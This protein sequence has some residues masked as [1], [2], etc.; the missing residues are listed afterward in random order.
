MSAEATPAPKSIRGTLGTFG[1][2]FT[3]SLLTILGV[4][5]FLR[6]GYVTGNAGLDRTLLIVLI[7]NAV[8]I[9]TSLSLAVIATN[10]PVAG[11]GDYF[12]ISRS[13]GLEFGGAIGAVLYVA[14][15]VSVGFYVVGFTE[16][17]GQMV[18]GLVI[19]A[20]VLGWTVPEFLV[21]LP[22][23]TVASL[24]STWACLC[25]FYLAYRGADI[26][27]KFQ[28][29]IMAALGLALLSYFVGAGADFDA[30]KIAANRGAGY[31]EGMSFWAVFAIFFPAITGFTQGVSMS[32]DLKDPKKSLPLGTFAAVGVS[33][34]VYLA[35]PFVL[36][37][38]ADRA[39][40]L[41]DAGAETMKRHALVPWLVDIGVFAATLSSALA[42]LMGAPRILRAMS[43]D[44]LFPGSKFFAEGTAG[45]SEPRRA[46]LLT[47]SI[48]LACIWLGD[49]NALAAVVTMFFLLSYGAVNY[50]TFLEGFSRNPSFRPRF[51]FSGWRT[52]LAG[53]LVC[54][55]VMLAI[56][57]FATVIAL[58]VLWGIHQ[59]LVWRD[60]ESPA[61][62]ARRGFYLQRIK[63]YLLLLG[64]RPHHPRSWRPVVLAAMRRGDDGRPLG[65]F[66]G[67]IGSAQ[68]ILTMAVV[69]VGKFEEMVEPRRR[70]LEELDRFVRTGEQ[71]FFFE[72]PIAESFPAGIRSLLLTHGIGQLRPN[73]LLL[74]WQSE[75]EG[76][77][78][79]VLGDAAALDYHVVLFHPARTEGPFATDAAAVVGPTDRIIDVWWRGNA[80][81]ALALLLAHLVSET[82][83]WRGCRIRVLRIVAT[84]AER[85]PAGADL[86]AL[87]ESAR[88]VATAEVVVADRPAFD[89][90]SQH[91]GASHLVFLGV[92]SVREAHRPDLARYNDVL[93]R[94]PTT[95]LVSAAGSFDVS[96]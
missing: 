17:L 21:R 38:T 4:I 31:A 56:D 73:T 88:F 23:G 14:Q 58:A 12:L 42:S 3:P 72:V 60:L 65:R 85:E 33:L 41:T 8:S 55:A 1:G 10:T 35:L 22:P 89:V 64:D 30:S 78:L 87:I 59:Y 62:D 45:A 9:L 32:G 83:D 94:L 44:E 84:D 25:L 24:V 96:V 50:A 68:G 67:A 27:T 52:S 74:R 36:A 82:R 11:G 86:T 70:Q 37:G 7:A 53:A 13:V 51:R 28:Y 34:V 63:D 46:M 71:R 29:V 43:L 92:G 19:P 15:S 57:P 76:E 40:L 47:L 77:Y 95:V 81:G 48:A 26:A 49:L 6:F 2:V 16:A 20:H 54:A 75:I 5:M 69:L 93:D 79:Q 91:S 80:N 90:I 61:G 39:N 18:G 66:A